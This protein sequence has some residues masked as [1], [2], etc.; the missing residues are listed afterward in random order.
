MALLAAYPGELVKALAGLAL[1]G[2]M[3]N[4]LNVALADETE[5]DAAVLTFLCAASGLTLWGVGSA[6]WAL[7][8]GGLVM[9]LSRWYR[10]RNS[11]SQR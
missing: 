8:V 5:R 9:V 3:G 7:V 4:A 2:T 11:S 10:R 6:F 1:L